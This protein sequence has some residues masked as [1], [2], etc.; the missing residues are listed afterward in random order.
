M[1]SSPPPWWQS[2]DPPTDPGGSPPRPGAHGGFH[3]GSGRWRWVLV[4]VLAVL[5]LVL[6]AVLLNQRRA[7]APPPVGSATENPSTVPAGP[8]PTLPVVLAGYRYSVGISA[9][10][11]TVEVGDHSAPPGRHFLVASLVVRNDQ[12]E[13]SA[14]AILDS[15]GDAP[16][17]LVGLAPVGFLPPV[18][19]LS[20]VTVSDC[21]NDPRNARGLLPPVY[22]GLPAQTCLVEATASPASPV[23]SGGDDST[24]APGGLTYGIVRTI[25]LPDDVATPQV[26]GWLATS[27]TDS[28]PG[29]AT[30]FDRVPAT[31]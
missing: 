31:P 1:T 24:M 18:H 16:A 30:V 20:S 6:L 22:R 4:A 12:R 8:T 28:P 14:P 29:S 25:D 21:D 9:F 27:S 13:R 23:G 10:T 15:D 3:L 5:V 7:V 11:P 19:A 17:V 26:S 2:S